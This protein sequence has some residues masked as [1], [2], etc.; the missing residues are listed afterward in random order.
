[1]RRVLLSG[2]YGF[3]N[4]GD[5]AILASTV[6][7]LRKARP[8]LDIMVLSQHP[9]ETSAAYGVESYPRMSMNEVRKA[10]RKSDLVIFG[11]GSLLQDATS[12]RSLLYYLSIIHLSCFYNKPV[13]VYANGIGPINSRL[14]RLLTKRAM[15]KVKDITV[16]DSESKEELLRLGVTRDI[17]VTADPAFLLEPAPDD[18]AKKILE[19]HGVKGQQ[20]IVWIALKDINAPAW[21]YDQI[22]TLVSEMR[23][24]G[25][26]PCFLAM[27]ERDLALTTKLNQDIAAMNMDPLPVVSNITPV[28]ALG[29][30]AV[31][32]FCLGMR[33]HTL[34]LSSRVGVPFVGVDIDPKISAFCRTAG[35]PVL[36]Y[37][38]K[39]PNFDIVK[40]FFALIRD[41][42]MYRRSLNEKLPVF[43][44]LAEENI[45]IVLRHLDHI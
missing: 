8:D 12:F 40:E 15:R 29:I 39:Y 26:S 25:L 42:D 19:S 11:G 18:L 6:E 14:G 35:C 30:L 4:I 36:P 20:D 1:M 5:E 13:V 7:A 10:V 2:Y 41:G 33:L 34:I 23:Q 37:P 16:R 44:S 24:D 43:S 32:Q 9:E 17:K 28:D 45:N 38:A 22:T 31:G 21:F 27:Q 3:G